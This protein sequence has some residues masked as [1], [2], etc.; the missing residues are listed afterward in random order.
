MRTLSVK[1]GALMTTLTLVLGWQISTVEPLAAASSPSYTLYDN[2]EN[3]ATNQVQISASYTLDQNAVMWNHRPLGSSNYQLLPP[4]SFTATSTSVSTASTTTQGGGNHH[5]ATNRRPRPPDPSV[6]PEVPL[7]KPPIATTPSRAPVHEAAPPVLLTSTLSSSAAPPS[8]LPREQETGPPE[9]QRRAVTS[10]PSSSRP[11]LLSFFGGISPLCPSTPPGR[12]VVVSPS[13][14][15]ELLTLAVLLLLL[16][17]TWKKKYRLLARKKRDLTSILTAIATTVLFLAGSLLIP[18]AHAATQTTPTKYI[19]NGRLLDSTGQPVTVAQ[20]IRFSYWRSIDFVSTDTTS[21]GAINT[22]SA[23]YASWQEVH[24]V[25]P[26]A[27]GYFSVNLG[28]TTALLNMSSMSTSTLLSLYL[29]VEVKPSSAANTAYELLDSDSTDTTIDRSGILSVPFST[30]AD[31][32]DQHDLGT[33]SGSIP[34][35]GSGAML[36]KSTIPAGT[37]QNTFTID[38][39]SSAS[40]T[41]TLQFGQTLGKTLSYNISSGTFVFNTNLQIQ[42]NLSVT[43]LINGVDLTSIQSSTGSLKASSGGGLSLR[44]AGGNYRLDGT[45]TAYGGGTIA[46]TA[47]ATNY[48]FFG[49]GGLSKNVTGFPTSSSTIP[50]AYVITTAG[51]ISTVTD[52]RVLQSD[53]REQYREIVFSPMYDK[54]SYVGD[55]SSNVGQLSISHDTGSLRNYYLWTSTKSTLQDY[56]INVRIPIPASFERWRTDGIHN[57]ITLMYR[58]TSSSTA[59]N[60]LDITAYDTGGQ[61]VTL[62]GSVTSL[63]STSWVTTGIEFTGSP[64]WTAGGDMLLKL[65]VSAKDAAQMHLGSLKLEYVDFPQGN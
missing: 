59:T 40:S 46:M 25:T 54:A 64:T 30:N 27:N 47:S 7:S 23:N 50:I 29:Q 33:G 53:D 42:G 43:G 48:V 12:I 13:V 2:G 17:A 20:S 16:H 57:A 36:E 58:S 65:K 51:S 44:I 1:N 52:R 26:N 8:A 37:N 22:G 63:A 9:I 11:S 24:T 56:D 19:Y 34:L 55:G 4:G 21:T 45:A 31:L 28:D 10:E 41:I 35:L 14:V 6:T 32:L 39:D 62:S 15:F 5:D 49:S 61:A 18:E 60:K 38:S 3:Q